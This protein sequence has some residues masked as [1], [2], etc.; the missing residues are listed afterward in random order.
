M[1]S[2]TQQA[3]N[4]RRFADWAREHGWAVRGY[5]LA[6]LGRADLAEDLTQEVFCRAWEAHRRYRE[7]GH[8]RAYLLR[9]A[10]RLVCDRHRKAGRELTVDGQMWK[11]IEPAGRWADPSKVLIQAEA[12]EQ[13]TEALD[14]LS[15]AQ[16]RVLLL[17]YYGQLGFTEIADILNCPIST[18]LSHCRRGL[19][20]LRKIL[21]ENVP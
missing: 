3:E 8:A 10:D 21:V 17:R 16:R 12:V 2:Q 7:Q 6:S 4:E 15:S 11:Q 20:A 18:A 14:I 13:L 1:T 9:I 19:A 5:L